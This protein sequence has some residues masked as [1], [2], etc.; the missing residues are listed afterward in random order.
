MQCKVSF[1][2]VMLL[3][4]GA[5][6][7]AIDPIMEDVLITGTLA[8]QRAL[9][10]SVSVLDSQQIKA[11]NK[12]TVADLLRTLPGLL[13][14]EQGGPGGL[15][16]VSIRG[17]E[18]NFTLVLLDGIEVN[19]PTNFRGGGFDFANLNPNMV[20]RIEVVRGAQSAIYGSDAVA[21][22]INII[23]RKPTQGH[24]Q[25]VYVELGEHDYSEVGL[26]ALGSL[27]DVN[28]TVELAARDDGKPVPGSSRENNSANLRIGWQPVIGHDVN[29][30]YRY[31]DGDRTSYPEQSGGPQYAL[32]DEQDKSDYTQKIVYLG[33]AA[34]ISSAW[35]SALTANRFEAKDRYQS[36]GIPPYVEVP[37]NSADT[38]FLR[39]Q[40]QWVNSLQFAQAYSVNVGAD[41]RREDGHSEGVIEYFG[42]QI[43]TDFDLDRNT[44]GVSVGI[45]ASPADALLLQGSVRYDSP[46]HFNSETS[47]QAGAQYAA[48]SGVVVAVN[49]GEAYKLP[50]FFALG[51]ALVGNPDLKPEQG[52]SWDLGVIWEASDTLRLA[53][54]VFHNDF[55]DLVD[56]DDET[57]RNVNRSSVQTRG[58]ELQGDWLPLTAL[59]LRS[60]ATYT[61]ID[62]KNE[63]TVLTG[64]P[65]W[66]ASVVAQWH[67]TEQLNAA[68]D[69][70][71][72]GQQW[73]ASRHTGA[74]VTEELNDF[75]RLD[76]VLRWQPVA[77]WQ[78]QLSADNLLNEHYETAVGFN[79]PQR[80]FRIGVIFSH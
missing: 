55:R 24:N 21:G 57:F 18:S 43:P 46:E 39:D 29:L 17:G 71:Y 8:P 78:V 54:T 41:Y 73:A 67:I 69:Y 52:E 16:A 44:F 80:E 4:A 42:N 34:Q 12:T 5:A 11:L 47:F 31:I 56:F 37:L 66:T 74:E 14:E 22:V 20:D 53:A 61:D 40:M 77:A 33:W 26:S 79:A 3:I 38:D 32:A 36:P 76:W 9:T 75:G 72:T 63:D 70:V 59:T 51:H 25:D 28:Y 35:R 64:R 6:S 45:T 1:L 13:V 30:G 62:V 2:V 23:T 48:G 10:S 50:S 68:L 7:A 58:L 15:T 49:W 60:Q 65:E 19:D 27:G